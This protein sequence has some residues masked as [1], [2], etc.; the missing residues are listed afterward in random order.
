MKQNQIGS[1]NEDDEVCAQLR[2]LFKEYKDLHMKLNTQRRAW[3][4]KAQRCIEEA[5]VRK[6]LLEEARQDIDAF[7]RYSMSHHRRK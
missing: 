3:Y 4:T 7:K 2:K 6:P 5:G 1:A